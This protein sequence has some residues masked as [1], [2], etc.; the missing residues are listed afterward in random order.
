MASMTVA[1][2]LCRTGSGLASTKSTAPIELLLD[3]SSPCSETIARISP[4]DNLLSRVLA[5]AILLPLLYCYHRRHRRH[6]RHPRHGILGDA[7]FAEA[8][9]LQLLLLLLLLRLPLLLPQQHQRRL[10]PL[11]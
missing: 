5:L 4:S 1:W 6:R 7:K 9:L 11:L 3:S 10:Q 2:S 8:R